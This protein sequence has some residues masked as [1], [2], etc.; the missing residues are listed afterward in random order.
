MARERE[1]GSCAETPT[2]DRADDRF[3]ILPPIEMPA[4][5]IFA[6]GVAQAIVFMNQR[7]SF[8]DSIRPGSLGIISADVFARRKRSRGAG[9]HDRADLL[10]GFRL[11][12][13]VVQLVPELFVNCIEGIRAI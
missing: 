9:D 13:S 3:R 4:Q 7:R 10:V 11:S 5:D 6:I 12:E 2:A 1:P 8:R